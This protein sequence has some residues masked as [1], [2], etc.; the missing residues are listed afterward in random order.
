MNSS[1]KVL[2]Y[3]PSAK[4]KRIGFVDLVI[5]AL[6]L[7]IND[8]T[9]HRDPTYGTYSVQ[10]PARVQEHADGK[11]I[12][13]RDGKPVFKFIASI[14]DKTARRRFVDEVVRQLAEQYPDLFGDLGQGSLL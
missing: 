13:A 14:P 12:I 8:C 4:G 7:R 2:A 11:A 6:G 9:L 10:F 5:P 3:R 1:V